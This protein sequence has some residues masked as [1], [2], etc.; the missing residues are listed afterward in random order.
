MP[1]VYRTNFIQLHHD[2]AGATLETE[3]LDFANS[4][5]IRSSLTEALRLGRQHRIQGWI[6]TNLKM[7]TIRPADQDWMNQSWFPEFAR[8]GVKRLAVVVSQDSL[9][10]MGINNVIQRAT[11]HVPFD[12]QYF[13]S[14]EEARHWAAQPVGGEVLR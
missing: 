14:P 4:E 13:A 3:W 5:Q 9:N 1:V 7:R 10:Q 11:E 12:T 2:S 6:G 8:L